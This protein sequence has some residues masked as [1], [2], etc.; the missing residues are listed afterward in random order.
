MNAYTTATEALQEP[1]G[2]PEGQLC[3][4]CCSVTAILHR[5][6]TYLTCHEVFKQQHFVAAG[7]MSSTFAGIWLGGVMLRHGLCM[8]C[9]F[10]LMV[11]VTLGPDTQLTVAVHH[12]CA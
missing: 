12:V 1:F 5:H 11:H 8:H 7:H 4:W 10:A 6:E 3:M 2:H 9:I